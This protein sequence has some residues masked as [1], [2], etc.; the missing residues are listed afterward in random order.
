MN[1]GVRIVIERQDADFRPGGRVVKADYCVI[2]R[3]KA[4]TVATLRSCRSAESAGLDTAHVAKKL[5][6]EMAAEG[7]GM[8]KPDCPLVP[9]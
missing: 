9:S 4:V 8:N 5:L 3:S 2:N 1:N 6:C 7:A